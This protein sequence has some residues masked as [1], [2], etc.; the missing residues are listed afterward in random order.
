MKVH[1]TKELMKLQTA[2]MTNSLRVIV[3]LLSICARVIDDSVA[4]YELVE[5]FPQ[6]LIKNA[7]L[8]TNI[9][10]DVSWAMQLRFEPATK[11]FCLF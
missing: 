2:D 10:R 5:D 8:Q 4:F 9:G 7:I 1:P 6:N 3:E 11:V